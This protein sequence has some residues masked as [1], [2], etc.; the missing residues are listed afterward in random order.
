MLGGDKAVTGGAEQRESAGCGKA[1]LEGV[2]GGEQR[3]AARGGRAQVAQNHVLGP[4]QLH[5]HRQPSPLRQLC[6]TVTSTV[7]SLSNV[8][9]RCDALLSPLQA[10]ITL[11]DVCQEHVCLESLGG[12]NPLRQLR[13]TATP[14][15]FK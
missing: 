7:K 8:L 10:P 14:A 6:T 2:G 9:I 3:E 15:T 12:G 5:Q 1:G 11:Q 13:T 4:R